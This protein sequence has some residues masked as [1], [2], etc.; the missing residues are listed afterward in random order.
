MSLA[1]VILAAGQGS[2]MLSKKQKILHE[3][4]G[5]PMVQHLF[6]TAVSL[7]T[8]PPVLIIGKGGDGVKQLLGSRAQYA[9]Q[10]EQLGT[11][12]ATQMA[13]PLLRGQADQVIVTYADMPLLQAHTLQKLVA[14]Q[15]E[16]GVAIAMLSVMGSPES[17]FGRVVRDE[18][19][20]V[21]EILE[22]AQA[23]RRPN[24]ADLL[25]IR[26]QNAGVYCFAAAWL[27]DNI[28][29]LPLRQAR[30]GPEYYLTDM[31]ELAVQ[32]N[33]G[34]EATATDDLDECL[35]AGTR[36]EMVVVEKAFRRR[37]NN[38]WLAQGIT[39]VDPDSTYIDPDVTIGQDTVI[40]PN[41]YLQGKT[42]VGQDCVIGPN[43]ILRDATIGDR[44][45]IEQSVLEGVNL[46][47]ETAVAPFTVIKN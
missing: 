22:V 2:R 31:I 24:A 46:A 1:I 43:T 44:C 41:S 26:E 25:A 36:A 20:R 15:A 40:W 47:S 19:G 23:K 42:A 6:D 37:A 5:K 27:W 12:H 39:I 35:G 9:V 34:V 11:G 17:T 8:I 33:R 3:V 7:T 32:Q 29:K 14:L 21:T 30:S 18:N 16:T 4:G 13:Q 45:H 10:S 38:R 28:E